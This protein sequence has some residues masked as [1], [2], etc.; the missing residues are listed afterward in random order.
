MFV[1]FCRIGTRSRRDARPKSLTSTAFNLAALTDDDDGGI[2]Q[3]G[4]SFVNE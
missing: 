3:N 2:R 4:M 1:T